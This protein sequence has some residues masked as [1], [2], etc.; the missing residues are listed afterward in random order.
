MLDEELAPW[1]HTAATGRLPERQVRFRNEPHV[2][3]VLA[4]GGY[5][6]HV[7]SG[8]PIRGLAAAARTANALVFHAGT[9]RDGDEIV[10]AGGRVLTVVGRGPSYEDA[11][12]VAYR[13]ASEITFD[14]M[15]LR[16]DIGRKAV[17][18][19]ASG[20]GAQSADIATA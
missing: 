8:K 9:R 19:I 2:G 17:T 10:T 12:A 15:Q 7:E 20:G 5:P 11:I 1:L 4:A 3:V 14:G 18:A 13:A 16:R 6:E